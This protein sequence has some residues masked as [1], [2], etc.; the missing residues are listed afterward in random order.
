MI[1]INP[2]Y[3]SCMGVWAMEAVFVGTIHTFLHA[4]APG[5]TER[6]FQS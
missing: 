1:E 4:P 6:S 3:T 2:L 5:C